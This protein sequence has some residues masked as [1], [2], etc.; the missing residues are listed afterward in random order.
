M[1]SAYVE[2]IV[3]S[4]SWHPLFDLYFIFFHIL[5]KFCTG[6]FFSGIH[7]LNDGESELSCVLLF[8]SGFGF[9]WTS[10]CYLSHSHFSK[11]NKDF[12][13][14]LLQALQSGRFT[15]WVICRV[16]VLPDFLLLNR[17]IHARVALARFAHCSTLTESSAVNVDDSDSIFESRWSFSRVRSSAKGR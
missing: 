15:N 11:G 9:G 10:F 5:T 3:Y 6:F 1:I 16:A 4:L 13:I 2:Q 8:C 14:S 12:F 17:I 7:S